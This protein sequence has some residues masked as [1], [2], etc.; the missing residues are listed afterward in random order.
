LG[1]QDVIA[2][3]NVIVYAVIRDQYGNFVANEAGEWSLAGVVG[4]VVDGDLIATGDSKSAIFSG[5]IIGT[6]KIHVSSGSLTATD[7]GI[8]TVTPAGKSQLIWGTQ[9]EANV[10]AGEIWPAFTVKIADQYGNQTQDTDSIT[11]GASSGSIVGTLS[12]SAA[13]GMSTFND[14]SRTL[15]GNLTLTASSGDLAPAPESSSITVNAADASQIRV[16]TAADGSGTI[17]SAKNVD[18]GSTLTAYGITRDR[19]DNYIGNPNDVAWSLVNKTGI[20]RITSY[21]YKV[22]QAHYSQGVKVEAVL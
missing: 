8:L 20:S 10:K 19:Y 22:D 16:E 1:D 2:G 4:G 9:P 13:A 12:Q 5:H 17:I 15:A 18:T 21:P 11:I 3:N 7:S 6:A 14:I